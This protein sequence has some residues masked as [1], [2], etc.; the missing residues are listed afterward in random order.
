MFHIN[1]VDFNDICIS[2]PA[3]MFVC[4]AVFENINHVQLEL[5]V[6]YSICYI[7]F[8]V[9]RPPSTKFYWNVF[10]SFGM[11]HAGRQD[12]SLYRAYFQFMY[13]VWRRHVRLESWPKVYSNTLSHDRLKCACS[14][15][16]FVCSIVLMCVR[17]GCLG[18]SSTGYLCCFWPSSVRLRRVVHCIQ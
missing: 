15:D 10:G 6:K 17:T 5:H 3:P 11:K 12:T 18:L 2:F 8:I 1:S 16:C 9:R 7:P 14:V 4:W 13:F